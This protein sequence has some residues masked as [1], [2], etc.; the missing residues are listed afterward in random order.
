M[1]TDLT[2]THLLTLMQ[3]LSPGFPIG[4]FSYS[5]GLETFVV[6]GRIKD[7]DD[8]AY[9]LDTVLRQG[10]GRND[11][12]L[13]AEG[14]RGNAGAADAM[15]RALAPSAERLHETADQGAAFCDTA[16]AVWSLDLPELTLPVAVGAAA[17]AM[18][19]P[20]AATAQAYLHAFA[21]ALTSAAQRAM[22]L[23]Q[24]AAQRVLA[25]TSGTCLAIAKDATNCT[26]DDLGSASFASDIAS[27]QHENLYSRMFR[28]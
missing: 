23:G 20:L 19:L 2:P 7:A 9:W 13:L 26:L 3:W 22:P 10:A 5:H 24:V 12:I 21:A 6:Q 4:A 15:A 25:A 16:N 14:W 18:G 17:R 28:S 1:P 8:L 27:M 11:C